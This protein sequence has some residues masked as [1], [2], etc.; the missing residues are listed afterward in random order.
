MICCYDLFL[1][2]FCSYDVD[3]VLDMI[4]DVGQSCNLK[5][6]HRNHVQNRSSPTIFLDF[7]HR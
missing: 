6:T 1:A 5:P 2:W 3:T 4:L 7:S